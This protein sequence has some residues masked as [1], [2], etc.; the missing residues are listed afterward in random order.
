MPE[1]DTS[2]AVAEAAQAE[3]LAEAARRGADAATFE[4]RTQSI[5]VGRPAPN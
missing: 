5:M 2:I 1:L 4:A 3:K